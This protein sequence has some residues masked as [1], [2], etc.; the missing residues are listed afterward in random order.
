MNLGVWPR[1]TSCCMIGND[2][3]EALMFSVVGAFYEV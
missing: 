2:A 3:E 1:L